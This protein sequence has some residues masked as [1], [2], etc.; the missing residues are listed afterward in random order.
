MVYILG[1][2]YNRGGGFMG[3]GYQQLV[4]GFVGQYF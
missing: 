4:S 2:G 1:G 3:D